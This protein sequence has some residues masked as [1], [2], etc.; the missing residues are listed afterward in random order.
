MAPVPISPITERLAAYV[1]GAAGMELPEAVIAKAIDHVTDSVAAILSGTELRAGELAVAYA[2]AQGAGG[3]GEAGILGTELRANATLAA[4]ANGLAA[5]ADETDDSHLGG[6]FHPGCA[7]IP[8]ALAAAETNSASGAEFL[9]AVVLGY[10]IGARAVISLGFA[11]PDTARHSSH[12][13]GTLFGAAAAA[14]SLYRLSEEQVRHAFSYTVQQCSGVPFWQRDPDHIEKAFDFAGM[15]ARNGVT[16]A[17]LVRSGFTGVADPFSGRHSFFSAFGE[18]PEPGE[19]TEGLGAR[20]EILHAT[21]KKWC[22]GSPIQAMLDAVEALTAAHHPDVTAIRQVTITM[23][24]DRI[25]IVDNRQMPATCAQHL[26]AIAL[27]D[28]GVS[29]ASS[30]DAERMADPQVLALRD[31]IRLLPSAELTLARPAR[32]AIVELEMAD[33]ARHHHHAQAVRG[34]PDNPMIAAEVRDKARD[35]IGPVLGAERTRTLLEALARLGDLPSISGLV[36]TAQPA[37]V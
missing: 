31:R 16:A 24:D 22:V 28:R 29:F 34:T 3:T 14:A 36:A 25:H 30:H 32:Q 11:R 9:R 5:H 35:L 20:F 8:A 19:L 10:D 2:R 15:G 17:S 7:I 4:F 18:N 13:I 33:G 27:L 26:V 1:A 37:R 21:I 12:S 23:P 6:R